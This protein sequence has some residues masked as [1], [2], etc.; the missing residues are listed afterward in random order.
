VYLA[1]GFTVGRV[2]H[3]FLLSRLTPLWFFAVVLIA[4]GFAAARNSKRALPRATMGIAV[5]ILAFSGA[6]DLLRTK[7]ASDDGGRSTGENLAVL[8][9]TRSDLYPEYMRKILPHLAGER[10]DKL[11]VLLRFRE[12]PGSAPAARLRNGIAMA[13]YADPTLE[14]SDIRAELE[15]VASGDLTAFYRSLGPYLRARFPGD[16]VARVKFATTL[17]PEIRDPLLEGIGAHGIGMVATADRVAREVQLGLDGNFPEPFF[18]GLGRRLLEVRGDLTQEHYFEMSAT[19]WIFHPSAAQDF[20]RR[21]PASVVE[22]LLRGLEA[23]RLEFQ[24]RANRE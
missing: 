8:A 7:A 13:L 2:Y 20:A 19:P 18:V 9:R 16:L 22:P 4:L 15:S 6:A 23:A 21:Q 24:V 11:R 17:P 10:S 1:S 12:E 14:L 5:T 3:Y